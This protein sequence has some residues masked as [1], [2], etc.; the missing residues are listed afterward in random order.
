MTLDVEGVVDG[1]MGGQKSLRLTGRPKALHPSLSLPNRQMR[2]LSAIVASPSRDVSAIHAEIAQR[3]TVRWQFIGDEGI[4]NEALFLQQFAYQFQRRLLVSPGHP[5]RLR[6][7][8]PRL[9]PICSDNAL[10][11]SERAYFS[12]VT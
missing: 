4:R 5:R 11:N 3:S 12:S 1:G 6:N 8:T 2:V 10:P 9:K 7:A